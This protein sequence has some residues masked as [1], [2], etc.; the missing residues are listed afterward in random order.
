MREP[1]S[2]Y[3]SSSLAEADPQVARAIV[4]ELRRQQDQIELIASEN[5]VSRAVLEAQGSVFTN[6]TVEGYVGRRYHGGAD[7][8]DQIEALATE[9]AQR[10][11]G[12]AYA[13]V[14]PHSGSQANQVVFLAFLKPGD[15]ILGMALAAGGHLS[16]GAAPNL[17]GKWFNVV[18]YG[19][20]A[21]SGLIDYD[22]VEELA[23]Q[24]Q[25][26]LIIAGGSA[27]PRV[28]DFGRFRAIADRVGAL[29]LVDMAH[30]AGLV[31]GGVHPSP[32]PY[33]DI[34][35]TT[36]YKS[37]RGARGGLILAND[38]NVGRK[39]DAALFPGLQGSAMLHAIA[40]KAVCLGEALRPAF[41][42]YAR[43]VVENAQILAST[44]SERGCALVSGGTDTALMLVDV[45]PQGLTG[46]AA[47]DSLER[48]GLTCNKNAIPG[49][50]QPPTL[51]S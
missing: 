10:L 28:I 21:S 38:V 3:F 14:Q 24:Q 19:V 12:C 33:A 22:E 51:T 26:K 7:Y 27:Y 18:Q 17:S 2:G 5:L 13:N 1:H 16:H 45:R 31:A 37:L 8:A 20:S 30:F 50:P 40:A 35:T 9:R 25:P 43:H 47:C 44:L 34:V 11:F 6:K 42:E 29:L 4:D 41:R 32:L 39:I 46:K 15:K 48:A 23:I 36:T 49:D